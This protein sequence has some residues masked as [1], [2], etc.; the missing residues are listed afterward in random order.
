MIELITIAAGV[1][2]GAV[3]C[4]VGMLI[5]RRGEARRAALD[6]EDH[7]IDADRAAENHRRDVEALSRALDELRG[8]A[9]ISLAGSLPRDAAPDRPTARAL[10]RFPARLRGLATV[11]EAVVAQADGLLATP[12]D[13]AQ[14]ARAATLVADLGPLCDMRLPGFIGLTV[15]RRG[16]DPLTYRLLPDWTGG[17]WLVVAGRGGPVNGL[18]LDTAIAGAFVGQNHVP[19]SQMLTGR[20]PPPASTPSI[21]DMDGAFQA[22]AVVADGELVAYGAIGGP[23]RDVMAHM[24]PGLVALAG[25][26]RHWCGAPLTLRL[27]NPHGEW[28]VWSPLSDGRALVVV[29]AGPVVDELALER[30]RGRVRRITTTS[31]VE[32]EDFQIEEQAS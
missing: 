13:D 18:A 14:L 31:V 28:L 16:Q 11:D 20:A 17:A 12:V 24:V 23:A 27:D 15:E 2:M 3:G 9:A 5:G 30:L 7:R 22:A 6:L 10:E 32:V 25:R 4:G 26:V 1:G 29:G 8:R 21:L 19:P